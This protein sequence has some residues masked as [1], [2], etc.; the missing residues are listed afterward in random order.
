MDRRMMIVPVDGG[1]ILR[2][3]PV[4][5]LRT[6]GSQVDALAVESDALRPVR[7]SS[8][9]IPPEQSYAQ[10]HEYP[11]GRTPPVTEALQVLGAPVGM[12]DGPEMDTVSG[13][14]GGGGGGSA[15]TAISALTTPKPISSVGEELRLAELFSLATTLSRDQVG[16]RLHTRAAIPARS[17][18]APELFPMASTSPMPLLSEPVVWPAVYA[19]K[20]SSGP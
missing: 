18:A 12:L 2:L 7:A 20:S 17:G 9:P 19:V 4:P 15:R 6:V 14:G 1:M 16:N 8:S 10:L 3:E 5:P 11:Y 13:L